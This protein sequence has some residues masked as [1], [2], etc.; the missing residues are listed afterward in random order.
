[1]KD[2]NKTK[3]QLI[4]EMEAMRQRIAELESLESKSKQVEA[5][6]RQQNEQL[7]IAYAKTSQAHR[8]SKAQAKQLVAF[9]LISQMVTSV[10][11]LKRTLEVVAQEMVHLLNASC[12]S[13]ALLNPAHTL[14]TIVAFY[15]KIP[16][17][18][19]IL[20]INIPLASN[21]S[22]I[23]AVKTG[24]SIVVP[25]A[26]N[27]TLVLAM[28][29]VE[30]AKQ[31]ECLMIIPLLAQGKVIGTIGVE[32]INPGHEFSSSEVE[33]A[34]MVAA[35]IAG[36]VK[37][38]QLLS[39]ERRERQIFESLREIAAV[40]ITNL[41]RDTILDQIFEQLQRVV[42][43]DSA[44]L[45]LP[46]GDDL[47]LING[48]NFD[49]KP[50][51]GM[52]IPQNSQDAVARVFRNKTP[53][54]ISDV[55]LDPYW[56]QL[57]G[58]DESIRGWMGVPL[59]IADKA[60]G[61]LTAD[62]F[63]ADM[64]HPEDA[65]M[66]QIFANQV[67][68]AIKNA[69]LFEEAQQA[70]EVAELANRAKS[71]F[72][73]TMS[74]EI[75]TPMNGIIGMTSLLFDTYLTSEQRDF[76]ETIRNSSD[77]LLTIIN[78]ILD[79]SKVE[80]G[81][82]KLEYQPFDLRQ[83][84][85]NALG[86]LATKAAEKG[87]DMG[88]LIDEGTPTAI[89]GDVTRVCQI[90]INLLDNALKFTKKGE[91]VVSVASILINTSPDK[92]KTSPQDDIKTYKLHF[93]I[94]DTGIGI[95]PNQLDHLFQPFSQGDASTT[96]K[97]GGTGLGLVI[98]QRL[99]ELMGGKIWVESEE[100]RGTTF[101]FTIEANS[102]PGFGESYLD[103]VQPLFSSRRILF[104]DDNETNRLMFK[105]QA[106][107][108]GLPYQDT[109]N[110]YEALEWLRQGQ[111]FDVVLIDM[112][113]PDMDGL[114]L[115][116]E[117]RYW[118]QKQKSKLALVLLT[119]VG[120]Q[121]THNSAEFEAIGF[122]DTLNKPLKA[123]IVFD[124]LVTIFNEQPTRLIQAESIFESEFDSALAATLP[125]H[126]LVAEDNAANQKLILLMLERLGYWADVAGNGL[127]V[128]EAMSRQ[129]YDVV[130]MDL[131]MP[132]MDGLETTRQ[133][134]SQWPGPEG[135]HI[136]AL[137]ASVLQDEKE[138]TI[139]A[140]MD[141]YVTKPIRVKDLVNALKKSRPY[142]DALHLGM[143]SEL[144]VQQFQ[145]QPEISFIE[146]MQSSILDPKALAR[147][148]DMIGGEKAMLNM[149]IDSF[150]E[151]STRLINELGQALEKADP[152]ALNMAAH[153]LKSL[154]DNFGATALAELCQEL[155]EIGYEG[156]LDGTAELIAQAEIECVY[157][158]TAIEAIRINDF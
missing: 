7:K 21:P 59:L 156:S 33:L 50:L 99:C 98:S 100:G 54:I 89:Y 135:P 128:L 60:I 81:K 42:H 37:N 80:S 4:Q 32:T 114:T 24:R 13:I 52:K 109:G 139:T 111:K 145:M 35:Q 1:M 34:E 31:I 132:E 131:N 116:T 136:I 117:I 73:A 68:I 141:D 17:E 74:H 86:L 157:V 15:T 115:A 29:D 154:S 12:S 137:T 75:R 22:S 94:R 47:V 69:R 123:S 105:R 148:N 102:A 133:I 122:V 25:E 3:T 40:L 140:D 93:S 96:R 129:S 58:S 11:D 144:Q 2:L 138:A 158:K 78:D 41:D 26:K 53:L 27:N 79:F 149:L 113:M 92:S 124:T 83:C 134:R 82:M 127:E 155:E 48:A 36:V 67:A 23:Q 121:Y 66:L 19:D 108:W 9:N 118:E 72:L 28:H 18:A 45:F 87:L 91:V 63:E 84:I 95:P 85:Q 90:L 46:E 64:Y 147:L 120:W 5:E 62:G 125:L 70:K 20:G 56:K 119:S 39:Q 110:P 8:R 65:Q 14:L 97:Y 6:L 55:E 57:E 104:V 51:I 76:A 44:G 142:A 126:I 30:R 146:Q 153:T 10:S 150:L 112:D 61:V 101:Y 77:V 152:T 71:T 107:T 103:E 143:T 88:Y 130:L 49:Y 43:F 106:N 151:D 16:Q 38:A